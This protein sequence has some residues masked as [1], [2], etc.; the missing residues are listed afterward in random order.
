SDASAQNSGCGQRIETALGLACD[1]ACDQRFSCSWRPDQ[2]QP[3]RYLQPQRMRSRWVFEQS[4]DGLQVLLD[5]LRDDD[6]VPFH[7]LQLRPV[8]TAVSIQ[9]TLQILCF[10]LSVV[11]QRVIGCLVYQSVQL[12]CTG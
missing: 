11:C 7:V 9:R 10:D 5:G 12:G 3:R 6:I 2:Q 8:L 4:N 1:Q